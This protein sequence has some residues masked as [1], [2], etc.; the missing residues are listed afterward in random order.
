MECHLELGLVASPLGC[1]LLM[2][3]LALIFSPCFLNAVTHFISSQMEAMKLQ[4]LLTQ[5]R[6]LGQ[7]E[8]DRI[9]GT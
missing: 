7:E 2:L 1:P 9:L 8:L 6:P 3:L 4:L 5:Y